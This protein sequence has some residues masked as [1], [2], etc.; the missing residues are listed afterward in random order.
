[1]IFMLELL[2][3][4]NGYLSSFR[5]NKEPQRNSEVKS[6]LDGFDFLR[7]GNNL[8]RV[9]WAGQFSTAVCRCAIESSYTT[10]VSSVLHLKH[11]LRGSPAFKF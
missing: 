5:R 6:M 9:M 10:K 1:M 11:S 2:L 8:L 3:F 7:K 4:T